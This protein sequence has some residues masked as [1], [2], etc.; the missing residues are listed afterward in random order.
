MSI[1]TAINFRIFGYVIF[2]LAPFFAFFIKG[3]SRKLLSISIKYLLTISV[4]YLFIVGPLFNL[5]YQLDSIV[6]Q[7]DRDGDGF[8]SHHEEA[9]WTVSEVRAHKMW[10]GDGARNV[11]G[12]L[13]SPIFASVYAAIIFIVLYVGYWFVGKIR[14]RS[15][16]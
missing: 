13:I 7:L 5:S 10:V 16:A 4:M 2:L 9:T 15:I 11:F 12:Y 6:I 8:I 1:D 14:K 3:I